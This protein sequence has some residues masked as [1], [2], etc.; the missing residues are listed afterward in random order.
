[1][2]FKN[3]KSL[4]WLRKQAGRI[5]ARLRIVLGQILLL[6][7]VLLGALSLGLIPNETQAM[8][9]GRSKLCETIA[10]HCS[11]FVAVGAEQQLPATFRVMIQ[12][13][14]D[15]LAAVVRQNDGKILTQ[16]GDPR[17]VAGGG[18]DSASIEQN[19]NVPIWAGEKRWG[20]VELHFR[21]LSQPGLWGMINSPPLRLIA[22]HP[23]DLHG[24]VSVSISG[25]CCGT[26]TRPRRFR[27]ACARRWT[28]W[29]KDLLVIDNDER[30]VLANQAFAEPAGEAR[31]RHARLS[32]WRRCRGIQLGCR[33]RGGP[34][35]GDW[36]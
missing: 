10:V 13:D 3:S 21:P 12:R 36:R 23:G 6:A 28:R 17:L 11:F 30:I 7:A 31:R 18:A 22:I 4:E 2:I 25:R 35:V 26:W 8:M 27:R 19:V 20:T 1:M 16:T 29:P 34:A 14:P 9:A 24:G 33:S 15:I 5:P 32:P